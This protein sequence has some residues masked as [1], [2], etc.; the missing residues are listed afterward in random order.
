MWS[1]FCIGHD[2][3]HGSFSDSK[4]LNA[5]VGHLTHGFLLVPYWPWARSHAQHHQFHNH[6][7]KD[8]SHTWST[9][10]EEN[11]G[12]KILKG[13]PFLV[14]FA[15]AFIY[16]LGG[17]ADG[18]HF[19]PWSKLFRNTKERVQCVVSSGVVGL[20]LIA[21]YLIAGS[22]KSLVFGYGMAWL[23]YNTVSMP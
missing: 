13:Q 5:I 21:F 22:L 23:C 6:K 11:K 4:T 2:C 3:G 16:L 9:R 15:Y 17:I 18:S 12:A 19:V 20:Y 14:P 8:M 7:D 10:E 1:L